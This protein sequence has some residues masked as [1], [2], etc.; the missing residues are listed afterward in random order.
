VPERSERG[1][2]YGPAQIERLQ[3]LGRLVQQ[4]HAIGQIAALG[5]QDLK[6]LLSRPSANPDGEPALNPN[7][8]DPVISAIENFEADRAA[9]EMGRLA[10]LLSPRDLVYQAALPLMREVGVRWHQ[11]KVST[12]QEHLVSEILRSLLGN[13]IRLSRPWNASTKMILAAPSGEWHEFGALAAAMLAS[14]MGIEPI[15]LGPNLPSLEIADAAKRTGARVIV[16]A[17]TV[18]TGTTME[19][20]EAT[21]AAMPTGCELWVSG[22][23]GA[24]LD[25]AGLPR[26][27][28]L[29]DLP[30]FESACLRWSKHQ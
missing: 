30:A 7:L 5:D 1:R 21:A 16:L 12:A 27:K 20:L 9:D 6:G 8:L 22:E 18:P 23:T 24:N 28:A 3:L 29:P 10:T 15:Y 25:L 4:G 14:I 26:T 19:D 2:Q 13:L 17:I 11:G